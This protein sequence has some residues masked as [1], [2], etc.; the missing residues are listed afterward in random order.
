MVQGRSSQTFL[1][2]PAAAGD[3]RRFV[4]AWLRDQGHDALVNR[5]KLA[6]SELAANAVAHTGQPFT[7]S[8]DDT[9]AW[10]RVEVVDSLPERMPVRVPMTGSA[11]DITSSSATG[12]GLQIVSAVSNRWGVDLRTNVKTLWCEFDADAPKHPSDP[13]TVDQRPAAPQRHDLVHLRFMGLP[14]RTAIAS[15]LDL[16][17]AIRDMQMQA[18]SAGTDEL[19]AL[20][21]LVDRSAP[22]RLAGRHAALHAAG[23]DLLRYDL[24]VDATMDELVAL[25]ELNRELAG[26]ERPSDR[27]GPSAD[28]IAFREWLSIETARQRKAKTRRRSR[29][30]APTTGS[31]NRP[32]VAT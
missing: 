6:V 26:L 2:D 25:G 31:G 28:V 16:D 20:L 7:V 21:N 29:S 14:V 11:I 1:A 19:R 9:A 3:A 17:D 18:A 30:A 10:L 24:D 5:V 23:A 12:R 15:G 32:T 22:L 13:K 27:R 4:G 8:V